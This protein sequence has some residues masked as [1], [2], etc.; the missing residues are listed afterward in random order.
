MPA[1]ASGL[2]KG[3]WIT[4]INGKQVRNRME[5]SNQ[6][7]ESKD[8][9][10]V[11]TVNRNNERRE[12]TTTA[13]QNEK[14]TWMIGIK[15]GSVVETAKEPA[16][17]GAAA[18]YA[19]NANLDILRLTG[20]VF[21]QLFAGERSVKD[22][23][24]AGPVGIVQII[25]QVVAGA[26]FIGLLQILAVISL[27]LG[28]FNLL[29]IPLLDG[30]QIMVLG[31]EKVMSWFKRELSMAVKEKIQLAGLAIILLLMV[32]TLFLDISRFF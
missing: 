18:R 27:N 29:P 24:L 16:T 7:S 32:F 12:I 15:F 26:G 1:A 25:A 8:Q 4:A 5:V 21:G 10:I 31:I 20:R 19:V 9:P 22:A 11:L 30:G 23:G 6:I 28:V 2:Q 13:K 17:I 14:G 3:D